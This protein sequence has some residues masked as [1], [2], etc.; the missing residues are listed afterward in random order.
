MNNPGMVIG[1]DGVIVIDPGGTYQVGK[2]VINEI[3]KITR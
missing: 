3:K 1:A 2:N